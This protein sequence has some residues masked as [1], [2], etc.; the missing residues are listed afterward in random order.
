MIVA[1][2]PPEEAMR[3]ADL[4]AYEILDTPAENDFDE[5]VQLAA[6][7]C[8]C[9]ISLITF[10]DSDRQWFK[11]SMGVSDKETTRDTSFCSHTILSDEI[12][13]IEDATRDPR[14]AD[15]PFVT[16][17]M[18][19]RFYAGAPI[20]SP[21]GQRLGSVCVLDQKPASLSDEKLR[22]LRILSHQVTKLLEL[23][24]KNILLRKQA[25]ELLTLK[26][27]ALQELMREKDER[28]RQ[29]AVELH[30]EIAQ[31]LAACKMYV[32]MSEE[33]GEVQGKLVQ[34]TRELMNEALEDVRKL[35]NTIS[36][37]SLQVFPLHQVL[38]DF[39]AQAQ[40]IFNF[41]IGLLVKNKEDNADVET[42]VNC[43]RAVEKWLHTLAATSSV[44]KVVL[45]YSGNARNGCELHIE[46]DGLGLDANDREMKIAINLINAR[47]NGAGGTVHYQSTPRKN[48]LTIQLPRRA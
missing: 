19:I 33:K 24:A 8:N 41:S 10:V 47:I 45:L 40:S 16:G 14:F 30:E 3:I 18:K 44:N 13:V 27:Y 42:G 48:V 11:A 23:R 7:L 31:K 4:K 26:D 46:D 1:T 12:M 37:Q 21:T 15:N 28:D 43:M 35:S 38:S 20:I 6:Q 9:P 39:A 25:T 34:R 17:D 29:V 5:L 36:R 2:L 22:A 32:E